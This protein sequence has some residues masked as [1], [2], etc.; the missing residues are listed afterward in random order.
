MV[1][2]AVPAAAEPA[3]VGEAGCFTSADRGMAVAVTVTGVGTRTGT[4][5]GAGAAV[6]GGV[7]VFSAA[8]F[9][10]SAFAFAF[11]FAAAAAAT[12][13]FGIPRGI[14]RSLWLSAQQWWWAMPRPSRRHQMFSKLKKWV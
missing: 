3:G 10:A 14:T 2:V 4:G 9:S 13:A 8:A 1:A 5:S 6:G 12:L 7:A 11:A